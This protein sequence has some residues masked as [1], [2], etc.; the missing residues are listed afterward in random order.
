VER[1]KT[2][3]GADLVAQPKW[4]AARIINKADKLVRDKFMDQL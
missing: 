2:G 3:A 1:S 4:L